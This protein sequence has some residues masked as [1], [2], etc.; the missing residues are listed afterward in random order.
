[1]TKTVVGE[2]VLGL[3]PPKPGK[4]R[5]FTAE[6]KRMLLE[7]AARPGGSISAVARQFGI[8]P[9]LLFYWKRQAEQGS[10]RALEAGEAV[11]PES[12]ARMLRQKVRE[13]ERLLGKKT[14]E[15]EILK[16]ATEIMRS[17]KW[18]PRGSSSDEGGGA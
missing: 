17:K 15:V 18:L 14:M 13:L 4:R 7:E 2:V 16:E 10:Q 6:Q 8:A 3:D 5:A 9:S 11:V 12:E 1:M